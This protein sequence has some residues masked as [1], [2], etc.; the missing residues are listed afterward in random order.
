MR[1]LRALGGLLGV[2]IAVFTVFAPTLLLAPAA[3]ADPPFRVPSYVT[4]RAGALKNPSRVRAAIDQLYETQH[5]R[6][7]V[8]FVKDFGNTGAAAWAEQ[9]MKASNFGDRDALL[10]V[11]TEDRAYSFQLPSNIQNVTDSEVDDLRSN[12]IEPALRKE[13]WDGA[14]IKTANGLEDAIASTF[15]VPWKPILGALAFGG[16]IVGAFVLYSW[17]RNRARRRAEVEAAKGID[18]SDAQALAAQSVDALDELS[19]S[20][21]VNVDNAVRTSEAELALAVEEFGTEQTTPFRQ[22]VESA[23]ATLAQSFS[24]RKQLDDAIPETP[25][26]QR[27]LL[28]EVITSATRADRTLD[29]QSTAF[30]GLRNLVINAP[31]RLNALTQQVVAISARVPES[32]KILAQLRTEFDGA[33]LAPIADNIT[34][35]NERVRFADSR[36]THG[37]ELAA[38]PMEGQQMSLVDAVRGAESALNQ[39]TALLDA[40][41]NAANN[42]RHATDALPAAIADTKSGIAHAEELQKQAAVP[43]A[44]E[45]AQAH[46]A[47]VSAVADAERVGAT[48][49]LT[50]FGHLSKADAELDKLLAAVQQEQAAA[51]RRARALAQA[52]GNARQKVTSVS[53]Y[54]GLHRGAIGAGARGDIA[55]AERSIAAAEASRESNP[56]NAILWAN[57]A[58]EL[59]ARAESGAMQE[60]RAAQSY[61]SNG[62]GNYGGYSVAGDVAGNVAGAVIG[63]ILR[64]M[65]SGGSSHH[66]S[67]SGSGSSS[68]GGSSRSSGISYR[69]GSGRF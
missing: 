16:I 35:A 56:S 34:E 57:R 46:D 8:V 1:L 62:Y 43:Y 6:L 32:E 64:G 9:T 39:A 29:E 4:D 63:G 50:A 5:V 30:D 52:I 61:Y 48:D 25:M 66:S 54:I 67:W 45:L 65:L 53:Q 33:A 22:A 31:D 19:K 60:V 51:E 23:K 27:R 10:A 58:A 36:I 28:I 44:K 18:P 11:A 68:Y 38:R 42:I 26:E 41:D 37:R 24:V 15:A 47:A 17:F 69:G 20:I 40:V 7:W 49:P 14:A 12:T 59:A 21:V 3:S 13:D 55:E 2:L